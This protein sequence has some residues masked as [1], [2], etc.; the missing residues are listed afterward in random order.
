M[1]RQL[2]RGKS[3][4][5]QMASKANPIQ[6]QRL[7]QILL[8]SSQGAS[9]GLQSSRKSSRK[10]TARS[11]ASKCFRSR[12]A[13]ADSRSSGP[14]EHLCGPLPS[15][16]VAMLRLTGGARRLPSNDHHLLIVKSLFAQRNGMH[17]RSDD[18]ISYYALILTIGTLL[19]A[20]SE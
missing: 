19:S 15:M 13:A 2:P 16:R 17:S 9:D 7:K 20:S 18:T 3:V 14:A 1:S 10:V 8:D 6:P 5:R 4:E 11:R 12:A